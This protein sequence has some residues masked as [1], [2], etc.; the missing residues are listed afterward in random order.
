MPHLLLSIAR[1]RRGRRR[2]ARGA[3]G[4]TRARRSRSCR[5]LRGSRRRRR[6]RVLRPARVRDDRHRRRPALRRRQGRPPALAASHAALYS[7]VARGRRLRLQPDRSCS[8]TCSPRRPR[9]R[10][11]LRGRR[12]RLARARCSCRWRS[13]RSSTGRICRGG[14]CSSTSRSAAAV[15]ACDGRR[16]STLLWRPSPLQRADVDWTDGDELRISRAARSSS[17]RC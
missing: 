8:A 3:S 12:R 17:G 15:W 7:H 11:S 5:E 13:A 4:S 2:R 10:G 6:R 1:A 9:S 14:S 16:S